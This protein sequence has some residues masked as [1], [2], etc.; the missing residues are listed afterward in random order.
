MPTG[1]HRAFHLY[2]WPRISCN[3]KEKKK[4]LRKGLNDS[5]SSRTSCVCFICIHYLIRNTDSRCGLPSLPAVYPSVHELQCRR[6]NE[7]KNHWIKL[8]GLGFESNELQ[9][10]QL[11]SQNTDAHHGLP[12]RS[13][14]YTPR[15]KLLRQDK[16]SK[17]KWGQVTEIKWSRKSSVCFNCLNFELI[18]HRAQMPIAEHRALYLSIW[19]RI[20]CSKT[21]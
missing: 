20:S 10:P 1:G 9:L 21:K 2:L 3:I 18:S 16:I 17:E 6:Q 7:Q 8:I 19:P 13:P 14:L 11:I 5:G 12:S 15:Y 4:N